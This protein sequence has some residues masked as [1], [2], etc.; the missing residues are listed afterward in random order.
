[1]KYNKVR[2]KKSRFVDVATYGFVAEPR[3]YFFGWAK[4]P[5]IVGRASAVKALVKARK[6]LP[7]GYNF[8]I[9]DCRRPYAVQ[10]RMVES[11]AKRL[12][13]LYADR[14]PKE[15]KKLLVRFSGGLVKTVTR[16]DTHRRGGSFD[17]TIVDRHG[18]ELWMGADHDDLTEKAAMDYYE[19]KRTLSACEQ[20]ALKNRRMLGR[21]LR[22]A[23]FVNYASE[24]WH[25]SYDK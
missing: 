9:W 15:R 18:Q 7:N 4:L 23:D 21:A 16:L 10:A 2:Q 20:E 3:Y 5:A 14:S 19:K 25:W 17:L 12:K 22:E 11:F 24:W 6:L 13:L 1:M 8:K